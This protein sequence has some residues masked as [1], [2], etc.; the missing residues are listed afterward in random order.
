MSQFHATQG[1]KGKALPGRSGAN[2]GTHLSHA[3]EALTRANQQDKGIESV[4]I[5]KEGVKFPICR[6]RHL[7]K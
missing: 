1:G 7:F 3:P 2:Q 6:L 4:P 5:G